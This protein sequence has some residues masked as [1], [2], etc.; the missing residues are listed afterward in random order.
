M[1]FLSSLVLAIGSSS[2]L[3]VAVAGRTSP[4]YDAHVLHEK[5]NGEPIAWQKDARAARHHVLPIRI[6]L[7][8][9]NLEHAERFI[10]DISDPES[11]NYGK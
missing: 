1:L 9:R 10:Y 2:A 5:R 8:Q 7:K 6:G 4:R 3:A 11:P